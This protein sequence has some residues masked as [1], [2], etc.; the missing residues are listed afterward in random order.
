MKV[1]PKPD[2]ID[3]ARE[4]RRSSTRAET[5]LWA[6]LRGGS[7]GVKFRRQHRIGPFIGDFIAL[8]ARLLV[9]ADGPHH[10][11][12]AGAD[13]A[14]TTV[15]EREGYRVLRF[16]NAEIMADLEN[17]LRRIVVALQA[18]RHPHPAQPDG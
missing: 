14:R 9:E 15:L 10:D 4:L 12:Q 6:A 2:Q 5:I 13:A 7:L 8:E 3:R 16:R 17:V 18:A 11:E 1:K